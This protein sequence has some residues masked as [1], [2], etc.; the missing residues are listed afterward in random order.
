MICNICLPLSILAFF[1]HIFGLIVQIAKIIR[2]L[3]FFF[4]S[5]I[6]QYCNIERMLHNCPLP[7]NNKKVEIFE[8]EEKKKNI[9]VSFV[10]N[11]FGLWDWPIFSGFYT[12]HGY[13]DLGLDP[14]G[15]LVLKA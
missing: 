5:V 4:K 2:Y 14:L 11:C 6:K 9:M 1:K 7:F 13:S 10:N 8:K 3:V 12:Q 15:Y